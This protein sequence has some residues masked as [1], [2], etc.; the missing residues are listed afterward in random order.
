MSLK[1]IF[2]GTPEFSVPIL[3]SIVK[4]EHNVSLVVTQFDKPSGRGLHEISNPIKLY[5][6]IKKINLLQSKK[7]SREDFLLINPDV[8]IVVAYGM[9]LKKEIIDIPK[10]GC[11]NLHPSYLPIYRGSAPIK[12]SLISGSKE[13][14]ISIIRLSESMDS[15]GILSRSRQIIFPWENSKK[16]HN[17]F[18]NMGS[19][20]MKRIL[21]CMSRKM[22][23][24]KKQSRCFTTYSHKIEKYL[25]I[26]NWEKSAEK[27]LSKAKALCH[28]PISKTNVQKKDVRILKCRLSRVCNNTRPSTVITFSKNRLLIST[29]YFILSIKKVQIPNNRVLKNYS[30]GSLIANGLSSGVN[31]VY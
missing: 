25:R 30:I 2:F 22:V 17:R 21:K 19:I 15:G 29:G 5:S 12:H 31:F 16:L 6:G 14:G 9:L 1:I 28:W 8:I 18:S 11:I 23:I 4:S 20:E 3:D 27:I 26:I 7:L 13:F 10:Y 24:S